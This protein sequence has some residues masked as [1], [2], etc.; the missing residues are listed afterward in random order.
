[1]LLLA[2]AVAA[3]SV[4]PTTL[5]ELVS[6]LTFARPPAATLSAAAPHPDA[7]LQRR[8]DAVAGSLGRGRLSSVVVDLDTGAS[9]TVDADRAWPAASLFKLPILVEVLDE[10]DAGR[11][12]A[13]Q[14][15]EIRSEDWTDGSGVLQA[16]V[17]ERVSVRELTRL[18]IQESDNIAALVLLD[19][20]GVSS[21][22]ATAQRLGL[23]A[24]RLVDHRAGQAGDHTTS[25]ADMARLLLLL[26]AGQAVNP[27]VS[28]E[29]LSLL[30]L[31][32]T[33]SWLGEDPPFWVKIAH[34]WG[35]L[36][37]ARNDAGLVFT[38][39]GNYV[40]VVLTQDAPPEDSATA[41]GRASRATYDY[42]G[43]RIQPR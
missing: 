21:V 20:V 3:V 38:P 22:N 36:P 6:G 13:E 34:K 43:A 5:R 2:V 8:L 23:R 7:E 10:A 14:R 35:D 39:R 25:A 17:G 1:L 29:A 30:E 11:L 9:A 16:R 40:A 27:H 15:L 41:I 24:T 28:E 26:A 19:A 18:M 33:F 12:D 31:K 37:D 4:G 42:L 32:Q